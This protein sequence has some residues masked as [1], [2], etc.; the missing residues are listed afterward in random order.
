MKRIA[1]MTAMLLVAMGAFAGED[2][3][4]RGAAIAPDAKAVPLAKVLESPETYAKTA[5][6]VDGVISQA[7]T[8]KGCWMELVPE[9][10]KPGVR[11]TFKDYGFFIPLD[12][13]G[14]VARA[15]GVTT[16]K[17]LSKKEADHLSEEGAK[18]TRNEDGTAREVSF[19]ANGVE[20][21]KAE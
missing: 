2:V 1:A 14:M 15:E 18:L 6:V 16:I 11:V 20:L 9:A 8:R 19:V 3:I 13:K 21:R 10:G 17:T 4:K 5:V 7:C 12:S